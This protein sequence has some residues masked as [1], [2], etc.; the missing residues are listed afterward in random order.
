[1]HQFS[2]SLSSIAYNNPVDIENIPPESKN[3]IKSNVNQNN[4]NNGPTTRSS[5]GHRVA[6]SDVTSQVNN[7]GLS[8]T[9]S[10]TKISSTGDTKDSHL[11][12]IK[13]SSEDSEKQETTSRVKSN[14]KLIDP[15]QIPYD[16]HI[17]KILDLAHSKFY[18]NLPDPCDED[19]YDVVMVAELT[20]DIFPY[21]NTL[22]NKFK[23][24]SNYMAYQPEI[25]WEH[26]RTIIGWLVQFHSKCRLLPE[27]L[28]LTI[29]IMDRFLSKQT[30][31][32]SKFQLIAAASLFIAAKY[33]EIN[34][35]SL[36]DIVY[37]LNNAYTKQ[38][39]LAAERIILG[40]LGFEIGWP[41][42]M[43]FLRRISKADNYEYEIRTLSKYFLESTLMEPTLVSA[44]PSWLA[45]GAYLLSQIIL[46]YEDWSLAHIYY[47]GYTQDQILPLARLILENCRDPGTHHREIWEKYSSR[48]QHC[49][50]QLVSKWI[51]EAERRVDE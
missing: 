13:T 17:Q 36:K 28:Y 33:E 10:L 32:I 4:A 25:E 38:E 20:N 16:V 48:Q 12:T 47:S 51:S 43:S 7:K 6:L 35:P 37:M 15:L 30:I 21:L 46:G 39:V 34:W 22:E 27:T 14:G 5:N 42:P 24:D 1:M 18:R 2:R 26:R 44:L 23:P 50:A 41:G 3:Y 31:S 9:S 29:N 11:Q 49:S 8:N 45:A 40:E 19:T